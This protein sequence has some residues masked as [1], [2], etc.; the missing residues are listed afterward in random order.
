MGRWLKYG[1]VVEM[2]GF[3]SG[4]ARKPCRAYTDL[5][6]Y[7]GVLWMQYAVGHIIII[8]VITRRVGILV[9]QCA[10]AQ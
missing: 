4:S 3:R 2:G 10:R 1:N 9:S 6:P 8:I 5:H 7:C